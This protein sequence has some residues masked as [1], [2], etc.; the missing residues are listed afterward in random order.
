M[1][2]STSRL[3]KYAFFVALQFLVASSAFAQAT[4][5]WVSGVGDDANPCSRTAPCKTWA[6]AISKTAEGGEIDALDPAGYGGVTITKSI[7]LSGVGTNASILIPAASTGIIVN[8][9][10]T[11]IVI[12]RNLN[13]HGVGTAA[14]GIRFIAG[15]E[16]HVEDSSINATAGQAIVQENATGTTSYLFVKNTAIR[17]NA[18]GGIHIRPAGTGIANVVL[19]RVTVAGNLRGIRV[20]GGSN[21]TI[22]N[23]S[24]IGSDNSGVVGQATAGDPRP[25]RLHIDSCVISNS[26]GT[27]AFSG[28]NSYM[29]MFGTLVTR[30]GTGLSAID[31]GLIS[32][33]GH[34]RVYGNTSDGAFTGTY[35]TL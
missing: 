25:I 1:N 13:L 6:G 27:G 5:T 21:V 30:N 14:N 24:V 2:T 34:N 28:L 4:R 29:V 19:D 22:S 9:G 7:T 23:S 11:D 12:I 16:L 8:A 3:G 18:G 17:N 10:A 15:G 26:G 31:A 32:S 20:E 33:L 35:G